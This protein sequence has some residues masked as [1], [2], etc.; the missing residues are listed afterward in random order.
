[1]SIVHDRSNVLLQRSSMF[2]NR[3][4]FPFLLVFELK[5][6]GDV[7][8]SFDFETTAET[9]TETHPEESH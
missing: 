6:N 8:G 1:M 5:V 7:L 9:I 3:A 2:V 4:P